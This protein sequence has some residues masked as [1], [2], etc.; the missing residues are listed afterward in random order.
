MAE[1]PLTVNAETAYKLLAAGQAPAGLCVEGV[2]DYS[3]EKGR[4]PPELFPRGLAVDVLNL[5]GRPIIELPAGLRAYE[6]IARETLL[7]TLPDDLQVETRLDL[8]NSDRLESLPQNLTVGTLTLRGC[9]ALARLPEGLDVWFLDLSGCWAFEHWPDRATIRSGRLQL[10]GCTALRHLPAY[11]QRL[12]ALNARDCPNLTSLPPDLVVTGWIDLAHSG[13]TGEAQLP[14]GC[15]Q[16]QLR[17]AGLNIDSRIAF[18]PNQIHIDEVLDEDNAERRRV[19]LDRYGYGRF[20]QDAKAEELDRDTDPGGERHLLRVKLKG[21]E[22]LV[23]MSCF[24]PS[25]GR[26]YM[27]R[28]PPATPT[29]QHAAAWIAGFDDPA[30]YQP[31]IET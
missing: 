19:L 31:L 8:S 13:L 28:V 17:W 20:L 3:T 22:D 25:T 9:T 16:S 14:P 30:D 23:A 15:R 12:S 4:S 24:C 21:D 1:A 29:C 27:L 26:Q 10:R 5:S 7:T 2:L 11:V 6:L 18:H